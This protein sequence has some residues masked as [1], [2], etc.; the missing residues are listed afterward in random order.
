MPQQ[1]ISALFVSVLMLN[2]QIQSVAAQVRTEESTSKTVSGSPSAAQSSGINRF[3]F[4]TMYG[5]RCRIGGPW[6]S[7]NLGLLRVVLDQGTAQLIIRTSVAEPSLSREDGMIFATRST[8]VFS[9]DGNSV[10]RP[11]EFARRNAEHSWG[12]PT[13]ENDNTLLFTTTSM[14]RD[15]KVFKIQLRCNAQGNIESYRLEGD[16]V[17]NPQWVIVR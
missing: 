5:T 2:L 17:P 4:D 16:A 14:G 8:L 3:G 12:M 11:F 13:K 6:K 15:P 9:D 7:Y 1:Q 10:N